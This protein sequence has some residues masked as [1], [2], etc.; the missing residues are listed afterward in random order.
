MKD[1][2]LQY[3]AYNL[4]ANRKMATIMESLSNDDVHRLLGGSFESV[5]KTTEHIL[6]AEDIWWQRLS[7]QEHVAPIK[8]SEDAE[9]LVVLLKWKES[10]EHLMQFAEKIMD[11]RGCLHQFHYTNLAGDAFKST[12]WECIHHV[13]NHSTFHRGQLI[14]YCRMLGV[15]KI[16][17][18]DFITY[19]RERK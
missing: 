1:I 16:P 15:Q 19:C 9:W 4:W 10:S 5:R 17:S 7:M 18:T 13:C 8:I 2:L 11:D 6:M 12:V 3:T 14:N